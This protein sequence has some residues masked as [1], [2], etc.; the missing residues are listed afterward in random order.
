MGYQSKK[1]LYPDLKN[2]ASIEK[3]D[4]DKLKHFAGQLN[5]VFAVKMKLIKS[6]IIYTS[7]KPHVLIESTTN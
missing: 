7:W 3:T 4:Q 5:S 1:S 2:D 6:S